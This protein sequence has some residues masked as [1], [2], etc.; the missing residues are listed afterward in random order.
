MSITDIGT[1][2]K[3]PTH[4][5]P[6]PKFRK[7]QI[8]TWDVGSKKNCEFKYKMPPFGISLYLSLSIH[9]LGHNLVTRQYLPIP[10]PRPTGPVAG[11]HCPVWP[12]LL[13]C[14]HHSHLALISCRSPIRKCLVLLKSSVK[15]LVKPILV[16]LLCGLGF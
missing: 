6:T 2:P 13:A 11:W 1:W 7:N 4:L 15:I 10:C 8:V 9:T 12:F 16:M 14:R 3:N 5:A